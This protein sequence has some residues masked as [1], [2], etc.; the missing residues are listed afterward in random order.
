MRVTLVSL[1]NSI[2]S[3]GARYVSS[4]LKRAG[5]ETTI[6]F[7][8]LETERQLSSEDMAIV[9]EHI[10]ATDPGMVGFSLMTNHFRRAQALTKMWK[11]TSDIPV[12]WG[13]IHPTSEPELC[14]DFADFVCHSEG[15]FPMSDLCTAMDEGRDFSRTPNIWMKQGKTRIRNENR[16]REAN[17]DVFPFQD[18]CFDTHFMYRGDAKAGVEKLDLPTMKST[19]PGT[20]GIHYIISS[21]GCPYSCTY[22]I[23]SFLNN[24]AEGRYLRSRSVENFVQEAEWVVQNVPHVESLLFMDDSFLHHPMPWMVEFNEKYKARINRPFMC[25]STPTSVKPKKMEVLID[26][27]LMSLHVGFETGSEDINFN[28]YDRR[29]SNKKFNGAFDVLEKHKDKV[30]DRRLDIITDD[31]YATEK[32]QVETLEMLLQVPKPYHLSITRMTYF[33]KTGLTERILKEGK[34]SMERIQEVYEREFWNYEPTYL[35]RLARTIPH[36]PKP[37][38]KW[39]LHNR[40]ATLAKALFVPYYAFFVLAFLRT[41]MPL[42]RK[43]LKLKLEYMKATNAPLSTITALRLQTTD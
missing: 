19:Y 22:C 5:H 6:L 42:K 36:M 2:V 16:S 23:N 11:E 32:D 21:R 41:F 4:M 9:C 18:Y 29:M 3:F 8:P 33:P 15:E 35:N 14:L 37:V 34:V 39:F 38:S 13:G 20:I 43:W 24:Q 17:L 10:K 1:D 28:L 40:K 30:L 25:W 26:A 12:I 27:G 31:P 7:V